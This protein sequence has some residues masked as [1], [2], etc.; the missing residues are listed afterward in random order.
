MVSAYLL[1]LP[2]RL[3]PMGRGSVV[4]GIILAGG[5]VSGCAATHPEYLAALN[6]D[7]LA[8]VTLPGASLEERTEIDAREGGFMDSKRTN[9][10]VLQVFTIDESANPDEVLTAAGEIAEENG[11]IID[12]SRASGITG[13]KT[14]STGRA[15]L[16]IAFMPSDDGQK[17]VV[18]LTAS[19]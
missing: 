14:L 4:L 12:S 13:H 1:T 7:P 16:G 8:D 5:I 3:R 19:W 17:L 15:E 6:G 9:A 10:A 2:G 18:N 11:W